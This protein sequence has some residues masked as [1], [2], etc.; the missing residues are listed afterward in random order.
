MDYYLG[1]WAKA[2]ASFCFTKCVRV[3][4]TYAWLVRSG[5]DQFGVLT[6]QDN[7]ARLGSVDLT[8]CSLGPFTTE[9]AA[10]AAMLVYLS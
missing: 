1:E 3:G 6:R 8:A 2:D 10:L 4:R 7:D 9:K 5:D